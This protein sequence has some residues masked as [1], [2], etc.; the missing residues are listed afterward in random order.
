MAILTHQT[1]SSWANPDR[2]QTR[3]TSGSTSPSMS[4]DTLSRHLS[5]S[6]PYHTPT[7]LHSQPSIGQRGATNATTVW[8]NST[9]YNPTL[10]SLNHRVPTGQY[11]DNNDEQTSAAFGQDSQFDSDDFRGDARSAQSS[12]TNSTAGTYPTLQSRT[13]VQPQ[14]QGSRYADAYGSE[15]ANAGRSQRGS[16]SAM[17]ASNALDSTDQMAQR[18][19]RALRF[20]ESDQPRTDARNFPTS[21]NSTNRDHPF[22]FNVNSQSWE[23]ESARPNGNNASAYGSNVGGPFRNNGGAAPDRGS[24]ISAVYRQGRDSPDAWSRP[25]S[26]GLRTAPSTTLGQGHPALDQHTHLYQPMYYSP[27][28]LGQVGSSGGPYLPN[29]NFRGAQGMQFAQIGRAHV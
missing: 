4:R 1:G 5:N 13:S 12:Y 23:P 18:L 24:A 6:S 19:H 7:P 9:T 2:P 27:A 8:N 28:Y 15:A 26:R 22:T 11:P 16:I 10:S 25:S 14:P 29:A 3:S 17:Q 20:G 21:R